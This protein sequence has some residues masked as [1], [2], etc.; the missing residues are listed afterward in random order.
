M[1][2]AELSFSFDSTRTADLVA[3]SIV[4]EVGEIAD[5]RA[6]ASVATNDRTVTVSIDARDFVA[7]RAGLNT[8]GTLLEV[9]ERTHDVGTGARRESSTDEE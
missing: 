7:L 3:A 5:H 9:A 8:W 4:Q 1:H 6:G 2:R